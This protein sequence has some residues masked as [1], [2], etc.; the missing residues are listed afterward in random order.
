MALTKAGID[1]LRAIGADHRVLDLGFSTPHIRLRTHTGKRLGTTRTGGVLPDGR[2]PIGEP[3]V[4]SGLFDRPTGLTRADAA[5]LLVDYVQ[6][7][8]WSRTAVN[9]R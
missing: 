2:Q 4:S 8:R 1:A 3:D 5:G 7:Q 9:V 6:D